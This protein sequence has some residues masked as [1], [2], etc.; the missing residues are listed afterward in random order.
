M[1]LLLISLLCI[2]SLEA[3]AVFITTG[4]AGLDVSQ[5]ASEDIIVMA[6]SGDVLWAPA[7]ATTL[8]ATLKK[9]IQTQQLVELEVNEKSS[10][11]RAKLL[12]EKVNPSKSTEFAQESNFQAYEPTQFATMKDMKQ[13]FASMDR[14]TRSSSQCYNR[15]YVWGHDL[16]Q[17][18][19]VNSMKL[20]LFFTSKYIREFR[21]KW[22]FH[23]SP[24]SYIREDE[25][26][27]DRLFTRAPLRPQTWTNIFMH[28]NSVCKS[29]TNY[30][31]YHKDDPNEYCF[32]IRSTMFYLG[33]T[34]LKRR[35]EGVERTKYNQATLRAARKQAFY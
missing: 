4:V 5:D 9:A 13:A 33:P 10:I 31:D 32:L 25:Y 34:A 17:D 15:A 24:M 29:V 14:D 8:I 20:F 19:G 3:K 23:V 2:F 35:D 1:K 22:W 12:P 6:T 27:M 16:W 11:I 18:R 30:F 26:V 7:R 28:N 21:Y